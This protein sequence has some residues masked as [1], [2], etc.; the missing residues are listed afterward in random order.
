M[1]LTELILFLRNAQE[2]SAQL[3]F[4]E[5]WID[6]RLAYGNKDTSGKIDY[7]T[8]TDP[9]RIWK[10]DL[11]FRNE[12][13]G[14]THDII[15]PNVLLRIYPQGRILY[16]IRISLVLA[17]PMGLKYYPLDKQT[18]SI[19]MA[20]CKSTLSTIIP[21][22]K[23]PNPMPWSCINGSSAYNLQKAL[24]ICHLSTTTKL[25]LAFIT[26]QVKLGKTESEN[27]A[28][29]KGLTNKTMESV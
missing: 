16:S 18:C 28:Y 27:I 6:D 26:F 21:H 29:R 3:T 14:H 22:L 20:S 4:R 1:K 8:L 15:M 7:L 2:Y 5:E 10:P 17:C 13:E 12:K 24:R 9:D 11:F 25:Y 23:C 19:S